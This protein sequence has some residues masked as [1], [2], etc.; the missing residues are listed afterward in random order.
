MPDLKFT[1]NNPSQEIFIYESI[2][3]KKANYLSF[4]ELF[5]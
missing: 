2:M 1:K 4:Q 3:H 5:G